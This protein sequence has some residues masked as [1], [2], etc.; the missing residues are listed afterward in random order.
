M[1]ATGEQ[2]AAKDPILSE[3]TSIRIGLALVLA[4]AFSTAVVAVYRVGDAEK[5]IDANIQTIRAVE[6][7]VADLKTRVTVSESSFAELTRKL[8]RMDSKIDR[9]L[10]GKTG[11]ANYRPRP[12]P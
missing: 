9:L 5:R 10:E 6:R 7:E 1:S 11:N 3:Q 2:P 4:S 8:D 12:T